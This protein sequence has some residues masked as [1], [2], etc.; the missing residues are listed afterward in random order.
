VRFVAALLVTTFD[1]SE[2]VVATAPVGALPSHFV[3]IAD[4]GSVHIVSTIRRR[5][6]SR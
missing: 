5:A 6:V 2:Y 4:R 3:A 1:D